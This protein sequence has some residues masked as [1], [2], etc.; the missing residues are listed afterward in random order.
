MKIGD[1]VQEISTGIIWTI[2]VKSFKQEKYLIHSLIDYSEYRTVPL[3]DLMTS[4]I[5]IG[6]DGKV[7]ETEEDTQMDWFAMSPDWILPVPK[8]QDV[9]CN[10]TWVKYTGLR[11]VYEF[12][13]KCDAKKEIEDE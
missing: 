13:S 10:H 3:A 8:G 12:C 6:L 9:Y 11:E 5:K 7:H 2:E 4:Y 1:V